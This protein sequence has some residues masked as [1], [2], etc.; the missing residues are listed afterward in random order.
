MQRWIIPQMTLRQ[1]SS[2]A[3]RGLWEA[4]FTLDCS[5]LVRFGTGW[6][7][8]RQPDLSNEDTRGGAFHQEGGLTAEN[9][10]GAHRAQSTLIC[11]DL[12]GLGAIRFD[13]FERGLQ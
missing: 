1:I 13:F 2:R 3:D 12:L 5:G 7:E 9:R 8:V 6:G 4:W 11:M 10:D